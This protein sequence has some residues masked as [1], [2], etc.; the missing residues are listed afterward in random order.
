MLPFLSVSV[1]GPAMKIRDLDET[2]G[3]A[4]MRFDAV[5]AVL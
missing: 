4:S 3:Y 5:R 1:E 2:A